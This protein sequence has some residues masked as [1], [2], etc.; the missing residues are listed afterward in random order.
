MAYKKG[1]SRKQTILFPQAID[2][3]IT[4]ENPV[5]FTDAWSDAFAEYLD[6]DELGFQRAEAASTG[7]PPYDPRDLLK[8]YIYGNMRDRINA[9]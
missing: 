4:E 7:P 5:R 1:G 3:Y 6:L 8:P 9:D 2:D